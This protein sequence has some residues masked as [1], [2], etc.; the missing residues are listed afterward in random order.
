MNIGMT[1]F[2]RRNLQTSVFEPAGEIEWLSNRNA[3]IHFG[4]EEIS[5]NELRK[6]KN[7][8]QYVGHR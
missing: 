2:A 6:I 5:I 1:T 8:S 4:I 7:N 3:T